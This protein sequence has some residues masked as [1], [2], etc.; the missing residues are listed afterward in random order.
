MTSAD[1]R[2]LD[3]PGES[4]DLQ[5]LRHRRTTHGDPQRKFANGLWTL[6]E[7]LEDSASSRIGESR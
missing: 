2:L 5:M 6:G 4:Q 7:E 3:Q 1:A